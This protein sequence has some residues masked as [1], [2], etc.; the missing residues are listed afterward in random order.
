MKNQCVQRKTKNIEFANQFQKVVIIKLFEEHKN[1]N[2]VIKK[3]TTDQFYFLKN[4]VFQEFKKLVRIKI[5][6]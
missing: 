3:L 6:I 2:Q 5:K 4:G 1:L